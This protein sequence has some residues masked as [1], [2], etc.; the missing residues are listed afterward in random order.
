V[1]VNPNLPVG[2]DAC[3]DKGLAR[4]WRALASRACEFSGERMSFN[5]AKK[6][7]E[8]RDQELCNYKSVGI[9]E[10]CTNIGYHWTG[11]AC[12]TLLRVRDDGKAAILHDL[13]ASPPKILQSDSPN[14]F[15]VQWENHS[16]PNASNSCSSGECNLVGGECV[17]AVSVTNRVVFNSPPG[18]TAAILA[19]LHF[20]C[21]REKSRW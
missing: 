10:K 20:G 5:T 7:C 14:F 2:S 17:C 21:T 11:F 13:D 3:C 6:R 8:A 16:Y 12:N 4:P 1:C 19:R 18:E 15:S 9:D